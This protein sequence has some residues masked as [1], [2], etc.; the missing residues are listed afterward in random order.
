MIVMCACYVTIMR[1]VQLSTSTSY[2]VYVKFPLFYIFVENRM[3]LFTFNHV[4]ESIRGLFLTVIS[5]TMAASKCNKFDVMISYSHANK[6]PVKAIKEK[7]K[8]AGLTCWIDEEHMS[9]NLL[10]SMSAAVDNSSIFLMCCSNDYFCSK[11]CRKGKT[12]L[13][14]NAC[15]YVN[16]YP[17]SVFLFTYIK[18]S[19]RIFNF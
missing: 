15:E 11:A 4:F 14:I 19:C 13:H 17:Y 8:E 9:G 7:L 1:G 5:I 6:K 3:T 2:I 18:F 12:F 10:D 16:A